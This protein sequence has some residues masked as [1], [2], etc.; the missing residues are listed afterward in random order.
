[1]KTITLHLP[2]SVD[3]SDKEVA[4]LVAARLYEQSKL[5]LGQGAELAGYS[6]R[7]FMELLGDYG[8]SVFN[9]PASDLERDVANAGKGEDDV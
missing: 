3:L 5:S 7:T 9:Y 4:T 8:V 1:M 2:D 6:K